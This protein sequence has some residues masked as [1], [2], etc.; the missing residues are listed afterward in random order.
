MSDS[1]RPHQLQPARLLCPWN[2]QGKNTG[3]GCHSL[4]QG[5]FPTQGSNPG[6]PH[7]R[8]I[9]YHLSH[10]GSPRDSLW[11]Y[12][13]LLSPWKTEHF[14]LV[15]GCLLSFPRLHLQCSGHPMHPTE[16]WGHLSRYRPHW[17]WG[18][19]YK[20]IWS[21]L[22]IFISEKPWPSWI[23]VSTQKRK[24]DSKRKRRRLGPRQM[25]QRLPRWLGGC[26]GPPATQE[27]PEMQVWSLGWEA[28]LEEGTATHSSILSPGESHG[29]RSL[30]SYSP[31][32]HK[33]LD[34]TEATQYPCMQKHWNTISG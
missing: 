29:Q 9:L 18:L 15:E 30:V 14:L 10:Q 25:Q 21:V 31:W 34:T 32:H 4:L 5:I 28:P 11:S 24:L 20:K 1:L 7:C 8:W 33:E 13:L 3:V 17:I 12:F 2:S 19:Q 6:L 16:S 27:T 26:K 22:Y 23:W